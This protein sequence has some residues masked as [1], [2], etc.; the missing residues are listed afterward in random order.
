[1]R[2]HSAVAAA[3][4][5]RAATVDR[6]SAL[7]ADAWTASCGPRGA[8]RDV[9]AR[10]VA[11]DEAMAS[12][13]LLAMYVGA[14]TPAEL[15][16][17]VD[18]L[19]ARWR[20]T[21][22][23]DLLAALRPGGRRRLRVVRAVPGT[24]ARLRT[25]TPFGRQPLW[26]LLCR[27]TFDEWL[28]E[29][30]VALATGSFDDAAVAPAIGDVLGWTVLAASP[31]VTL[32]WVDRTVGVARVVVDAAGP[33][34]QPDAADEAPPP[35]TGRDRGRGP[36][37]GRDRGRGSVTG[38]DRGRGPVTRRTWGVDFA[39]RQYGP[40]VA[41]PPDA[42]IRVTGPALALVAAGRVDR[43]RLPAESLLVEGD[44]DLAAALLDA[45]ARGAAAAGE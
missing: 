35:V 31:A 27:G 17:R 22:A 18:T 9:A 41:A 11:V 30:D 1:M 10:I 2:K 38:R 19:A 20:D 13:R 44:A 16:W 25:A 32:P 45:F 40:R 28:G 15:R 21:P 36:V 42:T 6:L 7:A 29:R 12:G 33:V 39:R 4:L 43:R 34:R 8:V 26:Y 37:T 24:A 14:A 3:R 5:Q 23:D